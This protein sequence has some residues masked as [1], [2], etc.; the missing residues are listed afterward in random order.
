MVKKLLLSI[1][2]TIIPWLGKAQ[3]VGYLGKTFSIGYALNGMPGT[4]S[5]FQND[6]FLDFNFK[7]SFVVEL[8]VLKQLGLGFSYQQIN[9]VVRLNK[10]T[11]STQLPIDNNGQ[12][13]ALNQHYYSHANFYGSA[14]HFYCKFFL[15]KNTGAIAPFGRYVVLKYSQ[16]EVE[17]TDDGRYYAS[18]KTDLQSV[19][20]DYL[21]IGYGTQKI[22]FDRLILDLGFQ[23]GVPTTFFE[24]LSDE[25]KDEV[26]L[27]SDQKMVSDQFL[28]L[29]AG[30]SL[31]LF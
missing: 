15:F 30:I 14:K 20:M 26:T 4:G 16:S 11:V 8:A 12:S 17:V 21:S 6:K 13:S 19:S 23:V 18:G 9:D 1:A 24:G 7:H 10:Y 25:R 3:T 28:N 5:I 27:V 29:H 2:C 22:Y 31:L